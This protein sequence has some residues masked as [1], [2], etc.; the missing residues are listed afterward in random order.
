LALIGIRLIET[1]SGF[2]NSGGNCPKQM[3]ENNTNTKIND[4]YLNLLV[5][6][7]VSLKFEFIQIVLYWLNLKIVWQDNESSII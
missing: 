2:C 6:E 3:L 5:P 1:N 4:P 7:I